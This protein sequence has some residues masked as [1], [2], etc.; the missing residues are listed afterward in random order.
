MKGP[1]DVAKGA[2]FTIGKLTVEGFRGYVKPIE[3][4]LNGRSSLLFGGNMSGKSSTLGAI[5]WCL[6]DDFYSL[7]TD[8]TRSK[9]ELVNDFHPRVSVKL[10]LI[11]GSKRITVERVK[12]RGSSSSHLKISLGDGTEIKR[13]ET[14]SQLFKLIRLGFEDFVRAVY[15]HQ[16]DVR[17]I[18]T[19]DRRV[20]SEAMDRLFGLENFRNLSD[21]LRPAVVK[22]SIKSLSGQRD[23]IISSITSRVREAQR[24]VEELKGAAS[25]VGVPERHLT[26]KHA[27]VCLTDAGKRLCKVPEAVGLEVPK[28]PLVADPSDIKA[29][30]AKINNVVSNVRKRIPEDRELKKI[31]HVIADLETGL[32]SF[33]EA[34][35][36]FAVASQAFRLFAKEYGSKQDLEARIGKIKDEIS[37]LEAKRDQMDVKGRLIQTGLKYLGEVTSIAKCPLCEKPVR[38]VELYTHLQEEAKTAVTKELKAIEEALDD[39]KDEL[40]E[41]DKLHER[42]EKLAEGVEKARRDL[43]ETVVELSKLLGRVITAD[44]AEVEVKKEIAVQNKRKRELEGPIRERENIL[45]GVQELA[46]QADCIADVL[47][48]QARCETLAQLQAR[49]ELN[50]VEAAVQKLAG[51]QRRVE[52]VGDV[53][54]ELQTEFAKSMIARSLPAIRDFYGALTGHPYYDSLDIEVETDARGGVVKN[55]YVIKGI[56]KDGVEGLASQKFSTGH[57]NCVGLSVFLA[58][59]RD[60]A[61]AHHLGFLIMDDPSQ[62]LDL[63]HKESLAGLLASMTDKRQLIVATQD[64]EFQKFL[65]RAFER[66]APMRI[67]FGAWD[68]GGPHLKVAT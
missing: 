64:A 52:M 40:A 60:D 11:R 39:A 12:Q 54:R 47:R 4:S 33:A 3:L 23:A 6:F 48:G 44:E 49:P 17:A 51:L 31:N 27:Q 46:R 18:I 41:A 37:R 19:E 43:N 14:V 34:Q 24:H 28:V 61:Y 58:L 32:R 66:A 63:I 57:L 22:D 65:E 55:L 38:R 35:A 13:T 20:R 25:R 56:A 10:E 68:Q 67:D 59:A 26:V 7:R 29:A 42:Q 2:G 1:T 16:E 8:R 53:V 30:V 45:E 5:E 50:R 21:G 62:N 15:L 36:N 9:D